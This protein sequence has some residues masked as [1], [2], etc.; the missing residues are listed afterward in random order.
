VF[1]SDVFFRGRALI[2]A[3]IRDALLLGWVIKHAE[4][5]DPI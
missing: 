3:V 4:G 2:L 5:N 1:G